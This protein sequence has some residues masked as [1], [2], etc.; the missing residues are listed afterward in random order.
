M[1]SDLGIHMERLW[2][3][4]RDL[5]CPPHNPNT[6]RHGGLRKNVLL[7]RPGDRGLSDDDPLLFPISEYEARKRLRAQEMKRTRGAPKLGPDEP[8]GWYLC[9]I[10]GYYYVFHWDGKHLC[11]QLPHK[12]YR[13][14]SDPAWNNTIDTFEGPMVF[15]GADGCLLTTSPEGD[16]L[17]IQEMKNERPEP[18]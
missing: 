14:T 10:S 7:R 5:F 12:D 11:D 3:L 17:I 18:T 16:K 8:P 9:T 1:A 2:W 6:M 4:L 15:V 13:P